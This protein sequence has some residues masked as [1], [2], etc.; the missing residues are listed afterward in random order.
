[1]KR[2]VLLCTLALAGLTAFAQQNEWQ[3][4]NVNAIN[5]APM[6]TNY[7]AF[8]TEEAALKGCRLASDNYLTLNGTWKFNWVKDAD[9]RPTDFYRMDFNDRG[10][11]DMQVPGIWEINGYGDPIYVN[12]GFPWRSQYKNNPPYVPTVNNHV[13]TY[14]KVIEIPADWKGR[15]IFA[16]F[17]SVTSNMYLYVNGKFVGYSE[18]SKLEAEFDLTKYLKPGKN[19]IAFQVFRWCDGTYLEDQDFFRYAGVGRDC[20]LYARH[21]EHIQDIRITPDLDA[22]YKDGTLQIAIEMAGKGTADMKLLDKAGKEVATAQVNGSGTATMSVANPLKWSAEAP[23]LYTLV[24]NLEKNGKV[25][26]SLTQKVGFR[27]I[28]LKGGQVLVNGQPVLFKGANRH[29]MDPDGGY[30]VSKERML[31]DIKRMKE[32]NINAVRTC[33]YPDDN[34]WYDLCD[35][36]GLY[37]VAEANVESHGMGYGEETLAKNPLY[38]KAH[39]ERN[40]RNVQR[41]YNHPSIIFWSLGNEAGFGP[42]FEACYKWIKAEDQTRP[43][44]YEQAGTNEFTDIYCPMYRNY[45]DCEEYAKGDIDKP[46]IQCEYAHAMGNSQGGFKEYWDLIRK[47]PKY[48]G[49]FIWDFVDQA[50]R[51][52]TK[53][54]KEFYGYGGDFNPYDAS[55]NNFNNNGLIGPDRVP[56]PHAYEVAYFYQNIWVNPV[57]MQ[58]G[59][60]SIYNENF[61]RDL[62]GYYAEWKLLVEGEAVQSG[63]LT[64]LKVAPQQTVNQKLNYSLAGICPEKEVLLNIEFKL[65]NG[66]MLLPAGQTVARQQLAIRDYKAPENLLAEPAIAHDETPS[67]IVEDNDLF[68]LIVKGENFQIDFKRRD[69]F[70]S[71]YEV[72]GMSILHE[73]AQLRPNFWRAPTDNDMGAGLQQKYVVWKNPKLELKSLEHATEN[74]MVV[75]KAQYD[76]PEVSAKLAL[77]YRINKEGAIEVTQS[78]TADKNAKVSNMFR[79]GMRTELNKDMSYIQYYGRGPIENYADRNHSEFIG[80]YQQTVDEQFYSYIRPQETGNKTDIRWWNQTTRGGNGIQFVGAEPFSAS[81]LHY[82]IESLDDGWEKDQRH[83][84][85]VPQTDYV[86]MCI[87]KV[88]SGLGCVNSWGT[89]PLEKYQLPY[90]DYTFTF[91]IKPIQHQL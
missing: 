32:L 26:E 30:V 42:N 49:G 62:S 88:Q 47:Y 76:M 5:R 65:K 68:Y 87:D 73:G 82:T 84:E 2:K 28:E 17:G 46:L 57:D 37:V 35:E 36:Y 54:G 52:H 27:K 74:G 77:T 16:H 45:E 67:P 71:L 58:K 41:G 4:A 85:L 63:I 40:Q 12:V 19:L 50:V 53:D 44:Q 89:L 11:D 33:H 61:F 90:Q 48:Q 79:F 56:N 22:Q 66:E 59:E 15:K 3:D 70:L 91:V 7:F 21:A 18:D 51:W 75:V 55:D 13:G 31:Q 43:V 9:Q 8:E 29:E 72:N 69:G 81:A 1:M 38:A 86:N 25:I 23:N 64:D 6:H 83:S 14:R 60:I 39:L 80:K 20:Y 24:V 34:L 10:W 78:M